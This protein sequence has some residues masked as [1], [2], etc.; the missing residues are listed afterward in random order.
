[1]SAMIKEE[2]DAAIRDIEAFEGSVRHL[3]LDSKGWPTIGMGF[4]MKSVEAF[5]ELPLR[6][7]NDGIR[8]GP[9]DA[10]HAEKDAEYIRVLTVGQT[11]GDVP[12][13]TASSYRAH[14]DL[15]YLR[16]IDIE[17]LARKKLTETYVPGIVALLPE[18]ETYPIAAKLVTVDIA[19]NGGLGLLA[20]FGNYL[21]CCKARD[22]NGAASE[23]SVS[24]SRP[25]RNAWRAAQLKL[26]A[27]HTESTT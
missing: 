19:W 21:H 10:T 12:R 1:M 5:Q 18:F 17:A 11:K 3:Y 2:L 20:K 22:W 15:V 16:E 6:F 26:A 27:K 14:A 9:R 13:R 24:S 25:E 23:S 8:I 4:L 7:R